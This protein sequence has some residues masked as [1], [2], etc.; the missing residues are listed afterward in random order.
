MSCR[1]AGAGSGV[2][3]SVTSSAVLC[4]SPLV[5]S[6]LSLVSPVSLSLSQDK[7]NFLNLEVVV[8][9]QPS[10]TSFIALQA[11]LEL[12]QNSLLSFRLCFL[13]KQRKRRSA[14]LVERQLFPATLRLL[15]R[16]MLSL[17]SSGTRKSPRLQFTGDCRLSAPVALARLP[18]RVMR[19]IALAGSRRP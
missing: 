14:S 17:S 5:L 9:S 16:T 2:T 19:H 10:R 3:H 8:E 1:S 18:A 7:N 12:K 15:L 11:I 4:L 6:S 13:Q